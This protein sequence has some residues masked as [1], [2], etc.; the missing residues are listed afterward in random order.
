[1]I[2]EYE[3]HKG[4]DSQQY[5]LGIITEQFYR[6]EAKFSETMSG[7]L[8]NVSISELSETE[9]ISLKLLK[10]ILKDQIDA[11]KFERFLNLILSHARFY[12]DLSYHV[13]PLYD[14]KAVKSYLNQLNAISAFVAQHI[15]KIRAGSQKGISQPKII[16]DG[17]AS[18]C[19]NHIVENYLDR[20]FYSPF[21]NLPKNLTPT[22]KGL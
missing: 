4:Y 3:N 10:F 5:P 6:S 20:Y 15:V 18:C 2:T 11:Y 9:L 21:K 12:N 16:F 19:E 17:Y 13:Q 8:S 14:S 1:M 22:Q 7:K